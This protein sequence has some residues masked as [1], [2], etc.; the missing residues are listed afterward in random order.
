MAKKLTD[1]E[2]RVM[3]AKA[4]A[5]ERAKLSLKHSFERIDLN[6]EV[7]RPMVDDIKAGRIVLELDPG[8]VVEE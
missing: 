3:I 7:I 4:R 8:D 6:E 5:V 1:G 2:E